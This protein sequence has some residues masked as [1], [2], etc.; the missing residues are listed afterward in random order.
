MAR[1]KTKFILIGVILLLLFL[2]SKKDDTFRFFG[3][4]P[5]AKSLDF[6]AS[7]T[8]A[9]SEPIIVST[10]EKINIDVFEKVHPA[11]VNIATTTL[12]MNFWMEVIPRQGQG[13]GFIID[14]RGYIM[15]NNHVVANAQEI[16]V[17]MS[18]GKKIQATLVG[19]DPRSDLAVIKISP[20][21]V[22][23]V[24]RL[25]DSESVRPGQKAI[26]IG[27]PFGLSHTLT[28]GIV[29]ALNR[30]IRTED[31]NQI[32]DL[33]QTDAAINP[34]NS[35]GPL[36]NS[37]GDVIGIN[38]AIFS[39]SGGYQGIGF[40]IPINLA[41]HVATQL[42]TS[43]KVARAWLGISGISITPSLS[44]GLN[45]GVEEGVLIVQ[46]V[47]GSPAYQARLKGGSREVAIGGIRLRLGGD[48]ITAI[49]EKNIS[50][51]EQLVRLLS[52]M[53]VGQTLKLNIFRDGLPREI[54]VLLAESP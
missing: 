50:D 47:R 49:D 17:T 34:G 27:N 14:S 10:D 30:S 8:D 38:T 16:I 3:S 54:N 5:T 2:W 48:I 44:E 13:S 6:N 22:D 45:L 37:N 18:K 33:I 26:A 39:L 29:S 35:G 15:T 25:G 12:G 53:R 40:A 41:K 20:G 4:S 31:G 24:A 46:V 21:E 32:D 7:E 11:V 52:K 9:E 19:R 23:R 42:I 51:M 36:L 28:T 1:D 43:G